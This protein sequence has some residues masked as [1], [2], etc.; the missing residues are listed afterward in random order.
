VQPTFY[1]KQPKDGRMQPVENYK[2]IVKGRKVMNNN[3]K[4]N[5]RKIRKENNLSQEQLAD[6]LGVSRQAISKWES[7]AAYPEMDKIIALCDKFNL[8]IDDLLH[9]DIKEVKGEEESKKKLNDFIN[10]FLKFITNTVNMFSNMNFK[11]KIKCLFEQCIIAFILFMV[12][13]VIYNVLSSLF[14]SILIVLPNV[15]YTFLSGVLKSILVI[16]QVVVS[17]IIITHIFKT[18]YLNYYE[19]I[20]EQR[21]KP[22]ENNN[23]EVTEENANEKI[24]FKNND[25]IIIRDSRHSEYNFINMMFKFIVIIIKLFATWFGL[26]ISFVLVCL[27]ISFI[28]SFL[29]Y[30]TGLFFIG[31]LITILSSSVIGIVLLLLIINFV[32]NRK[33]DKKKMIWSF[34]IS[35]IT[36]GIGCGLTF[37]GTLSF[38]ISHDS[39]Y[40]L[41]TVTKEYEMQD[42][43]IIL[44]NYRKIEYV[45][46]EDK[47]IKIEYQINKYCDISNNNY[48]N[49]ISTWTNCENPIE[50]AKEYIKN[51]NDKKIISINNSIEKM[52][53][54]TNK[55]NI[56]TLKNNL[57]KHINDSENTER[58]NTYEKQINELENENKELKLEIEELQKQ[59]D[60]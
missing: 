41:K 43:T 57:K 10:D 13:F 42:D 54:Y 1:K 28:A 33:N 53:V 22:E 4:E 35:L 9:K 14:T 29:I 55:T 30:K 52:T 34:I 60:N 19:R 15:I 8:N 51:I 17:I 18:R 56:E 20:K 3:F 46:T 58:I 39:E 27:F 31:L 40:M 16:A 23:K 6:E 12:S 47:N 49:T 50:I 38:D 26:C 59:L 7:G 45:E 37:I 36:F 24:I 32:F 44:N 48:N 25:K 2:I 11:S 5:L 21:I